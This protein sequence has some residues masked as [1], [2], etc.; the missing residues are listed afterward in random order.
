MSKFNPIHLFWIVPLL[1]PFTSCIG[2]CVL[3]VA[4]GAATSE[5]KEEFR[6]R[7]DKVY[8]GFL[9]G[10]KQAVIDPDDFK[11]EIGKPDSVNSLGFGIYEWQYPLQGWYG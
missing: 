8:P 7:V 11:R 10:R 4:V 5:S 6:A 2:L 3:L 9:V 1:P